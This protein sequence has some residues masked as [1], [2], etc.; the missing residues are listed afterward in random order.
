MEEKGD[1]ISIISTDSESSEK[2][3]RVIVDVIN[4][5]PPIPIP[6]YTEEELNKLIK[7]VQKMVV[8]FAL[9]ESDFNE[10]VISVIKRWLME[11]NELVLTVFFDGNILSACLAFPLAPVYDI[12]YFLRSPNHIF[13]VLGFHDEVIFGSMHEDV[14]GTLLC[15]LESVYAPIFFNFTEW[16]ENVKGY[17][18]TAL[19]NFL[20]Y[21]TGLHYKLSG[22]TVL[23]VPN[24]GHTLSAEAASK[25]YE[26]LKRLE[27]ISNQ[28]MS[29]I[30]LCL[31]DTQ[32]LVPYEQVC[33][34]DEFDFW[35]YR[36]TFFFI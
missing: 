36:C 33:P 30:R 35:V 17:I 12:T 22:L 19:H 3:K 8:L 9:K 13:T 6:E 7:Y 27:L 26:M 24:E 18:S 32:Q 25:D 15:I 23:Y 10:N 21:L 5:T 20:A 14:D 28:W 2:E 16:T 11:V 4:V 34:T 31:N 29:Q 1:N